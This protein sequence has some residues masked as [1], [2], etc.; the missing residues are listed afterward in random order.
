MSVFRKK[1]NLLLVCVWYWVCVLIITPLF[2][3]YL[4]DTDTILAELLAEL[5][6]VGIPV[7]LLAVS[8]NKEKNTL[9]YNIYN[10]KFNR[11]GYKNVG[12]SIVYWGL[13]LFL[14]YSILSMHVI[15][16]T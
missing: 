16:Y 12:V 10:K 1:I 2:M 4:F 7:A 15:Y 3:N 8:E 14:E 5:I 13:V 9:L 6:S 11:I